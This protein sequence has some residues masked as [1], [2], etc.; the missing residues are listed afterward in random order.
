M[1]LGEP[2]TEKAR[3][4]Y[5]MGEDLL[6]MA[7]QKELAIGLASFQTLKWYGVLDFFTP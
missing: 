2:I 1:L 5:L 4:F 3:K 6:A 7:L